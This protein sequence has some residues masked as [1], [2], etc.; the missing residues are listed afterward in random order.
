MFPSE[1]QAVY[2]VCFRPAG[3]VRDLPSEQ[4][5]CRYLRI[6]VADVKAA[7]REERLTD[8]ITEMLVELKA[9]E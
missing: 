6:A 7:H 5:P 1:D 8:T 2:I 4:S 3:G 9:L